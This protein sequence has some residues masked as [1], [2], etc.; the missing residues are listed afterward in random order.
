MTTPKAPKSN[1]AGAVCSPANGAMREGLAKNL[2]AMSQHK[3]D[4]VGSPNARRGM[5]D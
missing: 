4:P 5:I 2:D 1:G 3:P